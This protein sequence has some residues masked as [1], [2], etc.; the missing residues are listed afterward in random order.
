MLRASHLLLPKIAARPPRDH[1]TSEYYGHSTEGYR[2]YGQSVDGFEI[3]AAEEN[4]V[5]L[6]NALLEAGKEFDIAPCGLVARDSLRLEAGMLLYGQDIDEARQQLKASQ[7][8]MKNLN[9]SLQRSND[10]LQHFAYIASHDLQEPLRMVS[11]YLQ[12]LERRYKEELDAGAREFIDF[13]VD[14]ATRMQGM[15]NDLLLYSR[16]TTHGKEFEAIDCDAVL[17]KV[18]NNLK[19]SIEECSAEI[20]HNHLPVILGD[21]HQLIQVFQNLIT[22]AVKFRGDKSPMIQISVQEKGDVWEFA[23]ADNGMGFDSKHADRIFEMFQ[24]LHGRGEIAG[25]G[26][27]LAVIKKIIE[28]HGGRIWAESA[29]GEGATFRFTMPRSGESDA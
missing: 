9:E 18:L 3:Y 25:S 29:P 2:T 27:G 12:L 21:M 17:E 10:D 8:E 20:T 6:W 24:R 23:V 26:I 4:A 1:V 7:A 28:R 5:E 19:V 15:I 22:N 16:V 14:G 11:S 13:A